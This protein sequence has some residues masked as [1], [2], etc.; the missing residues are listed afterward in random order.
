MTWDLFDL[1]WHSSFSANICMG[2]I[3][4]HVFIFLICYTNFRDLCSAKQIVHF[5]PESRAAVQLNQY[6]SDVKLYDLCQPMQENNTI[7]GT[8]A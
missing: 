1:N 6:I 4:S 7:W 8:V 5:G 3:S 2:S